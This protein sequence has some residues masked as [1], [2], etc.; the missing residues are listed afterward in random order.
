MRGAGRRKLAV[1]VDV[2]EAHG[3]LAHSWAV[4]LGH[5]LIDHQIVLQ[6]L[7]PI[8]FVL[9]YHRVGIHLVDAG[10]VKHVRVGLVGR[11]LLAQHL[12][13]ANV[14]HRV[15]AAEAD[16]H[17]RVPIDP[18]QIAHMITRGADPVH[19]LFDLALNVRIVRFSQPACAHEAAAAHLLMLM[20]ASMHAPLIDP[21]RV[22]P[23]RIVCLAL[24]FDEVR[25]LYHR[26]LL[27]T[28][29]IRLLR[30]HLLVIVA[31]RWWARVRR[32]PS[33]IAFGPLGHLLLGAVVVPQ[34]V[35]RVDLVKVR[36]VAALAGTHL[37]VRIAQRSMNG[38][39]IVHLLLRLRWATDA[40]R[41]RE[42]L[43]QVLLVVARIVL[44]VHVVVVRRYAVLLAVLRADAH[45]LGH[46]V[47]C[48]VECVVAAGMLQAVVVRC[49][50]DGDVLIVVDE[51]DLLL[52]CIVRVRVRRVL[53]LP[54]LRT[55]LGGVLLLHGDRHLDTTLQNTLLIVGL[56]A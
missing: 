40:R 49:V 55:L 56:M 12:S 7:F 48:L 14:G 38:H 3:V 32:V 41:T 52:H 43:V 44:Q 47:L 53:R 18:I 33:A 26:L 27:A 2:D 23:R 10:A 54:L 31:H 21:R 1:R 16:L 37:L 22:L 28:N 20:H 36:V 24:H 4:V 19:V 5:L 35:T 6:C 39:S 50:V 42:L 17:R 15:A 29:L 13:L 25:R 34:I 45:L 51:L 46:V 11:I 30:A 9:F 8:D